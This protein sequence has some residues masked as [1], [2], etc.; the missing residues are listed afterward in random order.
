MYRTYNVKLWSVRLKTANLRSRQQ[1]NL[2]WS[3]CKM[4]DVFA[5]LYTNPEL[6]DRFSSQTPISN[7][8]E[9]LRVGAALILVE[10][11]TDVKKL[12]DCFYKG[13]MKVI[14]ARCTSIYFARNN[15]C[16]KT[17]AS[18]LR[19]EIREWKEKEKE[20]DSELIVWM[21]SLLKRHI[22]TIITL[23]DTVCM[24]VCTYV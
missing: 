22:W 16:Y 8:T 7:F 17:S 23:S 21:L 2:L 9:I 15:D 3:S 14:C 13:F 20:R 6:L 11:W 4:A 10:R 1:Q 12:W 18:K 19:R 5:Q 24:Y